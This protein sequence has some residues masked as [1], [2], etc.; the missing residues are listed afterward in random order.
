MTCIYNQ[1]LTQALCLL[2]LALDRTPQ[3]TPLLPRLAV[4]LLPRGLHLLVPRLASLVFE[5]IHLGTGLEAG[6][7][8]GCCSQALFAAWGTSVSMSS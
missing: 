1:R 2:V 6:L 3:L 7:G 8:L 4:T 5:F